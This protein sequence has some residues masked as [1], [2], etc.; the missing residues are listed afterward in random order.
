M[1]CLPLCY[2]SNPSDQ[3]YPSCGFDTSLC[4]YARLRADSDW[5][6][7]GVRPLRELENP[8]T[9]G[10]Q[11]FFVPGYLIF[12]WV[13]CRTRIYVVHFFP[14]CRP[15]NR[16]ILRKAWIFAS[17][18]GNAFHVTLKLL[19][20]LVVGFCIGAPVPSG[21][22]S[23]SAGDLYLRVYVGGFIRLFGFFQLKGLVYLLAVRR[24]V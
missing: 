18:Y 12:R 7:S 17:E 20:Q 19:R 14:D 21:L 8:D 1:R 16:Q 4:G 9:C 5:A 24:D 3:R 23:E 13:L 15:R 2:T 10:T 22:P 6:C 11:I